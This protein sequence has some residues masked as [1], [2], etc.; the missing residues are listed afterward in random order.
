MD[1]L[2]FDLGD[3]EAV[4][5]QRLDSYVKAIWDKYKIWGFVLAGVAVLCALTWLQWLGVDFVGYVN[6]WMGRP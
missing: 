4:M 5:W 1:C 3:V 2:V 6:D